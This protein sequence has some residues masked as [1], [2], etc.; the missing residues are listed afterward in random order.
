MASFQSWNKRGQAHALGLMLGAL[1][2]SGL[3]AGAPVKP[4]PLLLGG[5]LVVEPSKLRIDPTLPTGSP[6][7]RSWHARRPAEFRACSWLRPVCVLGDGAAFSERAPRLLAELE[8]AYERMVLAMRLPRPLLK[9]TRANDESLD[10]YVSSDISTFSAVLED[11]P[12]GVFDE[13]SIFCEA[14]LGMRPAEAATNCVAR[15]ISMRLDAAGTP[16]VHEAFA[17]YL[18][19]LTLGPTD[20]TVQAVDDFQARPDL[21]LFSD[22]SLGAA[23][24]SL[25][26]FDYLEAYSPGGPGLAAASWLAASAGQ[27]PLAAWRFFDEPDIFDVLRHTFDEDDERFA[28]FSATFAQNRAFFG[29]GSRVGSGRGAAFAGSFG[30]VRFDWSI[31]ASSLPRR[32]AS[33]RPLAP[34]GSIYV[35]LE[36]DAWTNKDVLGFEAKWEEPAPFKWTLSKITKS[37]E[38]AGSVDLVLQPKARSVQ[39]RVVGLEGL[40]GVLVIGTNLGGIRKDQPFDPDVGPFEPHACTVY[41]A[42]VPD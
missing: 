41:L 16:G 3:A 38:M 17:G 12:L 31:P 1:G 10:L 4:K 37:G 30:K 40:A 27:T 26:V 36:L 23:I 13:A 42:R 14:P 19:L 20:A 2:L 29:S 25:L 24:G 22:A 18:S 8:Q 39:Q 9:S 28:S 32:V 35:W 21:G 33:V 5:P 6:I 7:Y 34:N 11:R 15:A